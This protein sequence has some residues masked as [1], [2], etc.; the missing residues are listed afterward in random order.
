MRAGVVIDSRPNCRERTAV[1]ALHVCNDRHGIL[2]A[3]ASPPARGVRTVVHDLVGS[4]IC[5]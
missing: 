4:L 2:T 5:P 3:G 1:E